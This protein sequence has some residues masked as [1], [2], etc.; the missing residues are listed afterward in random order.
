MSVWSLADPDNACWLTPLEI[1]LRLLTNVPGDEVDLQQC[2]L[3][4]Y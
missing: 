2:Q 3:A 4:C 1:G